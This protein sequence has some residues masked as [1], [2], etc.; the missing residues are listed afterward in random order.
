MLRI[1]ILVVVSFNSWVGLR[2]QSQKII[3]YG[4]YVDG[5]ID[6]ESN[7]GRYFFDLTEGSDVNF[8]E[9]KKTFFRIDVAAMLRTAGFKP[10][11]DRIDILGLVYYQEKSGKKHTVSKFKKNIKIQLS[12][13]GKIMVDGGYFEIE[14]ENSG[15]LKNELQTTAGG[16][17]LLQIESPI[18]FSHML[19]MQARSGTGD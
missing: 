5:V 12:P 3:R 19:S 8:F 13:Y 7:R 16:K 14:I 2:A 6:G 9:L 11:S 17:L 18:S 10:V 4:C 1:I 15:R